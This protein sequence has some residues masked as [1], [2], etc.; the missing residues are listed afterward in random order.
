ALLLKAECLQGVRQF[1][2]ALEI[3]RSAEA[4]A[5]DAN[6]TPTADKAN[7]RAAALAAALTAS[8]PPDDSSTKFD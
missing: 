4:A 2:A 7:Q 8:A 3:Y 6:D 5:R 1:P